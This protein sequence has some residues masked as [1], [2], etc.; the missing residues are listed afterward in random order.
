MTA[1][2]ESVYFGNMCTMTVA[3]A[4]GTPAV[5]T[6]AVGKDIEITDG[7]EHVE[8]YGWGTVNRVGV[9]KHSRKVT[10]KIGWIKFAPKLAEWFPF[11]IGESAAGSGTPADTNAVTLFT[12]TGLFQPLDSTGTVKLLRTVSSVYFPNFPMKAAEGQF[13]KVDL[14]GYGISVV[15]SNP[16]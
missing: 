1:A 5:H 14:E 8:A 2:T 11:Y 10:V 12:I 3:G 16:A 6:L 9:A 13:V 7:W 15:D 4:S